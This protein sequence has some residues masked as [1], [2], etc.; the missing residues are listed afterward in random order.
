MKR[1][2]LMQWALAVVLVAA[3][4][5]LLKYGPSVPAARASEGTN[6]PAPDYEC[7]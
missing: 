6:S 4:L 1:K 2:E 7:Q 3:A 5:A